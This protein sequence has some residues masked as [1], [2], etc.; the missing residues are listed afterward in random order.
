MG[1]IHIKNKWLPYV[2]IAPT[3]ILIFIFKLYPIFESAIQGFISNEGTFTLE[4]YGHL[5]ADKT[6]WKSLKVT[7]KFNLI[8]IPLQIVIAFIMA[9]L[10]NVRLK[11]IEIFRTILYLPFCV[12]LTISTVIW[13]M[14]LNINNGVVNSF[15]GLFGI[16]AI[17]FL[18]DKKW[19]LLAIILIASWRGCAYWMMFIL[20]GLKGVDQ[21]V[22]E[23]AKM[24]GSGFFSTLFRITIPLLKNTMMFVLVANTTANF[25][26]FAPIQIATEG[27]P[28]GSTNVL[29]YEAYKSAFVYS[30][31]PR[32]ACI[33]TILLVIIIAICFVQ[34]KFM[35]EKEA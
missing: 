26:L 9:L 22:Y 30:N 5:F 27:G 20:A 18:I 7:L 19:A 8:T 23:S 29:M 16:K 12:S 6:F 3:V 28:Q 15:L 1:G 21:S 17:G 25:L 35:T 24:D 11:G 13:Q 34:S 14:L 32:Q 4:N 2:M 33:V 10:V 31:R